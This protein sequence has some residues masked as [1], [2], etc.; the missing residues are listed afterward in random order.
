MPAS[1]G[2][3]LVEESP[4]A[5]LA[6]EGADVTTLSL[7]FSVSSQAQV[8][9]QSS[10]AP[11]QPSSKPAEAGKGPT[12][13]ISSLVTT[14]QP[15]GSMSALDKDPSE[16]RADPKV[17]PCF[18]EDVNQA[19][20]YTTENLHNLN[21]SGPSVEHTIG[22]QAGSSRKYFAEAGSWAHSASLPRGYRRSE[23]SCRLSSAITPRPF[24][25]K[26]SKASS[27]PRLQHVSTAE[28][29]ISSHFNLT[30]YL[31]ET[32]DC[33]V[34]KFPAG[35]NPSGLKLCLWTCHTLSTKIL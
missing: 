10:P 27:L 13:Q 29:T 14:L 16:S 1:D 35:D 28:I 30:S 32:G 17:Q 24:S 20:V 9:D 18:P 31:K 2:T 12:S 25:T 19:P 5:S 4:F 6:S 3:I 23:G 11:A 22:P 26:H 8:K 33:S 15:N 34:S 7:E 21:T